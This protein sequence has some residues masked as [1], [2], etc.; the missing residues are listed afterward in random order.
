MMIG[1]RVQLKIRY[2][3]DTK[4]LIIYNKHFYNITNVILLK[5]DIAI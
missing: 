2:L 5:Q 4:E 1:T 3:T